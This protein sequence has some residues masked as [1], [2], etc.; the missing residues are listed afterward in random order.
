MSRPSNLFKSSSY[1]AILWCCHPDSR[2]A[3][4]VPGCMRSKDKHRIG[5]VGYD[6]GELS[7]WEQKEPSHLSV[8]QTSVQWA[9]NGWLGRTSLKPQHSSKNSLS[10]Q[11]GS[12]PP[13]GRGGQVQVAL[14]CSVTAHGSHR[15][16]TA[17]ERESHL[18][19]AIMQTSS[20]RFWSRSETT[21]K[22][23]KWMGKASSFVHLSDTLQQFCPSFH[24]E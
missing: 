13:W 5:C 24:L 18:E 16:N 10:R 9:G 7:W 21:N 1:L 6:L 23:Q 3:E 17:D 8:R 4:P 2:K 12:P 19:L 11:M 14:L 15:A 20:T 22:G